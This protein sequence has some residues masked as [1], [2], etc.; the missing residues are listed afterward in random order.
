MAI[1][2]CT[3]LDDMLN[4]RT[5]QIPIAPPVLGWRGIAYYHLDVGALI[6]SPMTKP[7]LP[8]KRYT[9]SGEEKGGKHAKK[10]LLRVVKTGPGRDFFAAAVG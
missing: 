1:I 6:D 4:S 2:L 10:T 5:G 8:A 3:F 9:F 7:C